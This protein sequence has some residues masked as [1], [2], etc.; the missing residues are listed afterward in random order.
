MQLV[1]D[2]ELKRLLKGALPQEAFKATKKGMAKGATVVS[3]TIRKNAPV[4]TG[5]LRRSTGKRTWVDRATGTINQYIGVRGRY[6]EKHTIKR[7]FNSG[8]IVDIEVTKKPILYAKK[9]EAKYGYIAQSFHQTREQVV[10]TIKR[11]VVTA[12]QKL[13]AR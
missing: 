10:L 9:I 13:K 8:R 12:F 7:R 4:A 2:K 6:E 5:T 11:E 1:G 3:T